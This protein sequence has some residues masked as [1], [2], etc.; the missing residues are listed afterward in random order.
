MLQR[1]YGVC[2]ET[3]EELEEHLQL[4]EEAKKRDHKKL[5]R[6]LGLFMMS[7]YAAGMPIFLPNGMILRNVLEQ[8]WYEEHTKEG[9]QFIKTPIMMSKELWETSGHWDHYKDNMYTTMVDEREFA[10]KPMN[11][12]GAMLVYNSTLH[13]YKD[14]PLRM[15]ELG[16]VHRHEA[17]GALNG[18]FRV[19]TFTQDDA[20]LFMRPDQVEEEVKRLIAFIDLSW[21][22]ISATAWAAYGSA[23]RSRWT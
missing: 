5:G 10:I 4:L 8:F 20:H 7:E 14:L 1:I 18:L 13:S 22:S 21:T 11:C 6:E 19:R 15:G 17:S 3:K 16:Q 9:Y 2:F 12:P 23:E